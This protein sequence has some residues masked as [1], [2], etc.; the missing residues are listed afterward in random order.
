M[1]GTVYKPKAGDTAVITGAGYGGIGYAVAELLASRFKVHVVLVDRDP[2]ALE[3]ASKALVIAGIPESDFETR[4]TDVSDPDE[5]LQ[6]ANAV[7]E[8]RGKVDFLHLNAGISAKVKAYGQDIVDEW[9]TT[10]A[11]NLFG[12]VNATSAFVDRMIAQVRF[13][14]W[15]KT[16]SNPRE[17]WGKANLPDLAGLARRRGHH[18]FQAGHHQPARNFCSLQRLQSRE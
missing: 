13:P 3:Q 14:S 16:S 10:F 6:L 18:R 17:P 12:V 15:R 8:V 2:D 11:V 4:L 7:Y 5:V 1:P 9:Q